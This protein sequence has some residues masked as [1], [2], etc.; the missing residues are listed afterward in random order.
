MNSKF[1]TYSAHTK[2]ILI[3]ASTN[4]LLLV[5]FHLWQQQGVSAVVV[6][7]GGI[8]ML[9]FGSLFSLLTKQQKEV[10]QILTSI[11]NGDTTLGLSAQHPLRI[12]FDQVNQQLRK[13]QVSAQSQAHYLKALLT[14][15]DIAIL[16]VDEQGKIIR[17]NPASER[18]LGQLPENTRELEELGK[19]IEQSQQDRKFTINWQK[20]DF[21]DKLSVHVTCVTIDSDA[22][23]LIS[24]QSVY[25]VL[26]AKEQ[27]AYKKLTKV[28]THEIANSI[29]PLTSLSQTAATLMPDNL[30]FA[31]EEDKQDLQLALDTIAKRTAHL[32]D[33][34]G[35]FRTVNQLPP[36]NLEIISLSELIHRTL[37]LFE[38]QWQQQGITSEIKLAS[39]Y[40]LMADAAQ[41][42]QVLINLLKNA[43]EAVN[44]Q[45][46]KHISLNLEQNEKMQL[47]IDICDTGNGIAEHV[48]DM[49]FVPFFTTKANG[50]GIGLSLSRHIMV[51]HGGDL[52]CLSSQRG[53]CFRMLF[54]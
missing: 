21:Q 12:K 7:F 25:H 34:I 37:K 50:S 41:L 5:S 24:I 22:V 17:K 47:S 46:Q 33:F 43:T 31:D 42:E 32:D 8:F 45:S 2:L 52:T 54:N 18:L 28:L 30:I 9:L 44:E 36:P 14:H 38:A 3:V 15:I 23:K 29:T 26:Q 48:L 20:A 10:S 16:V 19:L 53:A 4:I 40:S 27:Q 35:R 51:Q 49:I 1:A 11:T 6:L 13:S 39:D